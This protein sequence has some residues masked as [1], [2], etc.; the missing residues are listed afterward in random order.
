MV[1]R[2]VMAIRM[3]T[4]IVTRMVIR[5]NIHTPKPCTRGRRCAY[6]RP[7]AGHRHRFCGPACYNAASGPVRAGERACS[8]HGGGRDSYQLLPASSALDGFWAGRGI[9][10]WSWAHLDCGGGGRLM[11]SSCCWQPLE[12]LRGNHAKSA[13]VIGAVYR[14]HW[15]LFHHWILSFAYLGRIRSGV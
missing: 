5:M 14:G 3:N 2:T 4:R 11:G 13:S 7:R 10:R 1:I 8:M 12:E 6:P 15:H 9:Q